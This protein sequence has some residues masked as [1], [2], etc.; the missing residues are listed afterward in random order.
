[1]NKLPIVAF[2]PHPWK[3]SEWMNRQQLLSRMG[4]RGWPVI[5]SQGA[6]DIWQ[7]NTIVAVIFHVGAKTL[8][9]ISLPLPIMPNV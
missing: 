6:M 1:M 4:K 7:R 2:A 3:E 8:F 5:Y 9:L